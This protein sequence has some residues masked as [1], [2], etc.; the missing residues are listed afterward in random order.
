M[1]WGRTTQSW[2]IDPPSLSIRY[3]ILNIDSIWSISKVIK[4]P[5]SPT[6]RIHKTILQSP[7]L[8][9]SKRDET[10][11]YDPTDMD[12]YNHIK[13]NKIIF[14][15]KCVDLIPNLTHF[16]KNVQSV[17]CFKVRC[18]RPYKWNTM[19]VRENVCKNIYIFNHILNI[20][21]QNSTS[22]AILGLSIVWRTES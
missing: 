16:E 22:F 8:Q 17:K 15:S 19:G 7:F 14:F 11:Y 4:D 3:G 20:I 1:I 6:Y 9:Y 18:N 5:A 10:K 13:F 12:N 2:Y 21:N